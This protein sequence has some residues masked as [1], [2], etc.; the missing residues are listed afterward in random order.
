MAIAYDFLVRPGQT[1]A[2]GEQPLLYPKAVS[3][4]T[5]SFKQLAEDVQYATGLTT[6][7]VLAVMNAI[8]QMS[9]QYLNA[10]KHVELAAFGTLS[11]G[12]A[13][14]KNADGHMPDITSPSQVKPHHLHVDKVIFRAKPEF[15][16][17]LQ[18]PFVRAKEG[19]ATSTRTLTT[20]EERK[21]ILFT[22]LEQH[23][24]INI[25][26][27]AQLTGLSRK[28]A[29]AE[30]NTFVS[31]GLLQRHGTSTHLFFTIAPQ[32]VDDKDE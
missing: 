5:I 26:R 1:P 6:T 27:Y 24:A 18:G 16:A 17:Q 31:E 4:G 21:A 15:V 30:L 13:I 2:E 25:S 3:S 32:Q 8:T 7:D 11:V 20:M 14:E 23:Q 12:I 10:G 19:F 9:V 22:H 29:N 28:H